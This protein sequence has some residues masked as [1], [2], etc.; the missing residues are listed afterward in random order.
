MAGFFTHRVGLYSRAGD[1]YLGGAIE[2]SHG[3]AILKQTDL[4]SE[5]RIRVDIL[6][7]C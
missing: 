4:Q 3:A 2:I 1:C 6:A 5:R 7:N